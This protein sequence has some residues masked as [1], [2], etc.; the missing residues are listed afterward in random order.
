MLKTANNSLLATNFSFGQ[1]SAM[2]KAFFAKNLSLMLKSGVDI[3]EALKI[4]RELATGKLQFVVDD[5]I[6]SID[7][8]NS[9]SAA[10]KK[11]PK[12]FSELFIST[13]LAGETSGNLVENLEN[14]SNHLIK[15]SE[16]YAKIKGA[17]VYPVIVILS[18]IFLGLLLSFMVLPKILPL[19][20]SMNIDL[21]LS[22]K[23]LIY[24]THFIQDYR[25]WLL[26]AIFGGSALLFWLSKRVLARPLTHLLLLKMP[27]I[28]KLVIN[29]SLANFCSTLAMMLKSGLIID[30]ALLISREVVGNYYF[31]KAVSD[32][33][34][35]TLQGV[36]LSESLSD[37]QDIFPKMIISMVNVGERSGNLESSLNNLAAYYEGEVDGATKNLS[38]VIEPILLLFIGLVV[39]FLAV[40]IITPI[41]KLTG[42]VSGR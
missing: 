15:S 12:V 5:V 7:S 8:G 19:F 40:S 28:K 42:N 9:L 20:E 13:T 30:E 22:T 10:L 1:V 6:V 16:V 24:F 32:V 39:G 37:H 26:A 17:L 21:P 38:I 41:Y 35:K 2:Q 23:I 14:L 31:K 25:G 36:L 18:A 33:H 34:R 27:V 4:V 3:L 29:S 11:H